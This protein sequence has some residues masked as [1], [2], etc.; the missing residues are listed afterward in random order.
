[1]QSGATVTVDLKTGTLLGD[2]GWKIESVK[3]DQEGRPTRVKIIFT[4]GK[5]LTVLPLNSFE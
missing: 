5:C 1:M 3:S 2:T 4:D